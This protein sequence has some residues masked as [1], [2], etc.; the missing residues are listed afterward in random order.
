MKREGLKKFTALLSALAMLTGMFTTLIVPA[1]AED[2]DLKITFN[3]ASAVD[4]EDTP[5][6][7]PEA[8][9]VP[10]E[11]PTATPTETPTATPTE[12]PDA[13]IGEWVEASPLPDS[14]GRAAGTDYTIQYEQSRQ[15]IADNEYGPA[16][17][18]DAELSG[19]MDNTGKKNIR[20]AMD[21][22]ITTFVITLTNEEEINYINFL[23]DTA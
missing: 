11:E 7:T 18:R 16:I 22:D 3:S 12:V 15:L 6:D 17:V 9:D 19:D 8:T 23:A 10:T 13:I 21:A 20:S 4:V 2:G 1:A 5:T 14:A